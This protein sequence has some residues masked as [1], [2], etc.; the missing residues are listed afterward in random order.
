MVKNPPAMQETGVRSLDWEDAL[1]KGTTIH[2]TIL[3]WRIP[4]TEESGE[5]QSMG[6]WRVRH[7]WA[8]NTFSFQR[9]PCLVNN[10]CGREAA[11]CPWCGTL[12]FPMVTSGTQSCFAGPTPNLCCGWYRPQVPANWLQWGGRGAGGHRRVVSPAWAFQDSC[13]SRHPGLPTP[14]PPLFWDKIIVSLSCCPGALPLLNV[15]CSFL[16]WLLLWVFVQ[17]AFYIRNISET[18]FS[19][20]SFIFWGYSGCILFIF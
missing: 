2:S 17:S 19:I 4:W 8:T 5:L 12:I 20:L 3:A 14:P 16:L 13:P 6:L 11:V 10:A 9:W 1:E 15:M 18:F 7:D